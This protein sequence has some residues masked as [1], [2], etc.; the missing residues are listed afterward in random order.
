MT[1]F[2]NSIMYLHPQEIFQKVSVASINFKGSA[3]LKL[4]ICKIY[5][6]VVCNFSLF[7][8][9]KNDNIHIKKKKQKH[10]KTIAFQHK[11]SEVSGR[12]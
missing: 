10:T 12:M 5:Y 6:K 11:D 7:I 9:F 4:S 2:L 1:P 8:L 3:H